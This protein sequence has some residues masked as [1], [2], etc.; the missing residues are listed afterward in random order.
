MVKRQ[1]ITE[2]PPVPRVRRLEAG[3][4]E[5]ARWPGWLWPHL[6]SLDA[7]VVALVWQDWWSRSAHV[8][9]GLGERLVLGLGVWWI[10]LADR[11]ADVSRGRP[12]DA[13]TARHAFAA[14]WR[15]PLL[16]LVATVT[17]ALVG[18]A[19]CVL[20]AGEFRAGLGLLTAAGT[21]FWL[22]HRGPSPG[23]TRRLP[24][25]AVVGGMFALGTVFFALCLGRPLSATL[26]AGAALFGVVCF[27]NC[28]LI[29]SWERGLCDRR[30]P[31][32]LLNAFP[33]LVND[34]GLMRGCWLT[35]VL[36]AAVALGWGVPLLLPVALAAVAL[37]GLNHWRQYFSADALRCL[38]DAV[39]LTPCVC[40][41][42]A[43]VYQ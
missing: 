1:A 4:V 38:A 24:K 42:L 12:E 6:L 2:A 16:V 11:L 41:G 27:L 26:A 37:A 15:R 9:L 8:P 25:E 29:T 10:Y 35:A 22:I 40:Y 18:M 34:G 30:D 43:A 20:P 14:R 36:A 23:W 28:A 5:A 13:G 31:A 7:P 3:K 17:V 33:G 39:L 19:P 32:S 21:Y